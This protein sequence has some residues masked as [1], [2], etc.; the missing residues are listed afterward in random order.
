MN[1]CDKNTKTPLHEAWRDV[2]PLNVVHVDILLRDQLS[3]APLDVVT[4]LISPQN[5]NTDTDVHTVLHHVVNMRCWDLV[6]LP[7]PTQHG[8]DVNQYNMLNKTPRHETAIEPNVSLDAVTW[9][10]SP[11]NINMHNTDLETR[12]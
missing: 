8:A 10:I 1:L 7:V 2:A 9:L 11:Q 6:P 3:D 5:I 12:I 4:Q